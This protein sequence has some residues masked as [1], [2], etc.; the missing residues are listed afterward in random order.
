MENK[1]ITPHHLGLKGEDIALRCLKKKRYKIAA[2]RF[3]LYRGEIDIIAYD[4]QTLVFIEVKTRSDIRFG[5]PE[6]SV[7]LSKQN[8]IKKI[9]QGYLSLHNIEETECRFD[10]ISIHHNQKKEYI[11]RHIQKA[12]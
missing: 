2:T 3:K 8:Q 9:A 12:F 1:I 7:S 6:E 5:L 4:K 11:I 10:V